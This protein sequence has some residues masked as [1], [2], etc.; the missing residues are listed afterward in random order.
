MGKEGTGD[1]N[2]EPGGVVRVA[3]I[4]AATI[5]QGHGGVLEEDAHGL[6]DRLGREPQ[7]AVDA[8]PRCIADAALVEV[9]R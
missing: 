5:G 2:Y 8:D 7:R 3:S 1:P 9:R 4:P 6:F